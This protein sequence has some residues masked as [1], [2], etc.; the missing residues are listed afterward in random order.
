MNVMLLPVG[1][2][3]NIITSLLHDALLT[4]IVFM[5]EISVCSPQNLP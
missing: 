3:F 2:L 4:I 5:Y 1:A